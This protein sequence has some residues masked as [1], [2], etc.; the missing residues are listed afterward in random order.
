[1]V[2]LAFSRQYAHRGLVTLCTGCRDP[3]LSSQPGI[4]SRVHFGVLRA[5]A[6]SAERCR[7]C[8][9]AHRFSGCAVA[10]IH[11]VGGCWYCAWEVIRPGLCPARAPCDPR[12]V[13]RGAA[14]G[15]R[16]GGLGCGWAAL[17][18]DALPPEVRSTPPCHLHTAH[19]CSCCHSGIPLAR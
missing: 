5:G 14:A 3:L 18:R 1:C 19:R 4:A 6:P 16:C 13:L 2:G 17:P 10:W 12:R 11:T 7:L 8:A 9:P 15:M